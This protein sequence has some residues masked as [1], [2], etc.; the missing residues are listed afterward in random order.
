MTVRLAN[1]SICP[2][3][4]MT[5]Q[6]FLCEKALERL[7]RLIEVLLSLL[8]DARRH[9]LPKEVVAAVG[10]AVDAARE[11]KSTLKARGRSNFLGLPLHSGTIEP[12]S[13]AHHI[14]GDGAAILG[15]LRRAHVAASSTSLADDVC[16]SIDRALEL[17][18]GI[19]R[20]LDAGGLTEAASIDG[21]WN[22]PS[23]LTRLRDALMAVCDEVPKIRMY[24]T[25]AGLTSEHIDFTGSADI[26]WHSVITEAERQQKIADLVSVVRGR[27]PKLRVE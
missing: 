22:A 25:D 1:G 21:Y 7:P 24:A 23:S 18:T 13:L 19:L 16:R 12:A 17:T 9:D 6:D 27:Y 2:R 3:N 10:Q 14:R 11:F 26:V 20:D 15:A 4:D 5:E 8:D